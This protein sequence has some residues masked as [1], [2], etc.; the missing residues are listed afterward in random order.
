M[1]ALDRGIAYRVVYGAEILQDPKALALAVAQVCVDRGEQAQVFPGVALNVLVCDERFA[2]VGVT[3][4][5]RTGHHSVVVQPSGLLDGLIGVFESYWQMAVP[6]HPAGEGV[7]GGT[8]S[9]NGH[10]QLL[11]YLSAGLTDESIAR[12]LGGELSDRHP[13]HRPPAGDAWHPDPVPARCP[14][15]PPQ[16]ALNHGPGRARAMGVRGGPVLDLAPPCTGLQ[17]LRRSPPCGGAQPSAGVWLD[18]VREL[19]LEQLVELERRQDAP[20]VRRVVG[21]TRRPTG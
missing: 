3:A 9:M 6:L 12:E 14:G 13:A 11:S 20:L 16:L 18:Q 17:P 1:D 5:D 8:S 4:P 2:V 19:G 10:R 21:H 15:R 7:E